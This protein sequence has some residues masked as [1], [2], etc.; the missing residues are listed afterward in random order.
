MNGSTVIS[1]SMEFI[2]NKIREK[3]KNTIL[4]NFNWQ[5]TSLP[6]AEFVFFLEDT[7]SLSVYGLLSV[8]LPP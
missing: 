2:A 1:V 7:I 3:Q 8:N 6:A 5:I 4:E